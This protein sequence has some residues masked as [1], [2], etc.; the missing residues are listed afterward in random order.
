MGDDGVQLRVEVR[1]TAE[2]R[3]EWTLHPLSEW[4]SDRVH[5]LVWM[6]VAFRSC[7]SLSLSL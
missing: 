5:G 6:E 2:D 1:V 3:S 4:H 7:L